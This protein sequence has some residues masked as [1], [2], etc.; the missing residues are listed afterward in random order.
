MKEDTM[1]LTLTPQEQEVLSGAIKSA[2]SDLGP[3]LVTLTTRP[4]GKACNSER[5]SCRR[6]LTGSTSP[7][8]RIS[9][10]H[11]SVPDF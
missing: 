3:R 9:S 10:R 8:E 2:I 6:F 11:A 1:Q 7:P 4:C 5:K